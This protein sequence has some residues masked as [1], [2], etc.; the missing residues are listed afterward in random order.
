MAFVIISQDGGRA[1]EREIVRDKARRRWR[2]ETE[3]DGRKAFLDGETNT[4]THFVREENN[5]ATKG[6]TFDGASPSSCAADG[7]FLFC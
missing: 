2:E 6:K 3:E 7:G 1:R 5:D 4:R